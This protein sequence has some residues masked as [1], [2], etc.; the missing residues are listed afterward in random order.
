MHVVGIYIDSFVKTLESV[1]SLFR[2]R[3]SKYSYRYNF[4]TFPQ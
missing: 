1:K 2:R 4:R 3:S